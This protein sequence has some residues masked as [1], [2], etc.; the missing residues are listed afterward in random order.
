MTDRSKIIEVMAA[1]ICGPGTPCEAC[2]NSAVR[3]LSALHAEGLAVVPV[4]E[5]KALLAAASNSTKE[6][7]DE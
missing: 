4:A 7:S 1:G 2:R 3:A 5:W 6:E